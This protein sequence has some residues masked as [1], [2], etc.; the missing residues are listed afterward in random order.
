MLR[1]VCR[2]SRERTAASVRLGRRRR[3]PAIARCPGPGHRVPRV[4]RGDASGGRPRSAAIRSATAVVARGVVDGRRIDDLVGRSAPGRWRTRGRP[5]R[6]TVLDGGAVPARPVGDGDGDV[7]PSSS[8]ALDR[9]WSCRSGSVSV[10]SVVGRRC[11]SGS[12]SSGGSVVVAAGVGG[13]RH[14]RF[15]SDGRRRRDDRLALRHRIG[16]PGDC[17][18][19][20]DAED[21]DDHVGQPL[22]LHDGPRLPTSGAAT[23]AI[24]RADGQIGRRS[25]VDPPGCVAPPRYSRPQ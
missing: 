7:G 5:V 20:T 1:M 17:D 13:G 4:D 9:W 21:R 10:G 15:G 11:S 19:C 22:V 12:V 2:D 23:P 16:H 6:S 24:G 14:G 8:S 18:T 3:R 25:P